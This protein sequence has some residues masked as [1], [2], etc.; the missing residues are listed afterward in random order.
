M[1]TDVEYTEQ[2]FGKKQTPRVGFQPT[3]PRLHDRCSTHWATEATTLRNITYLYIIINYCIVYKY[4]ISTIGKVSL[5]RNVWAKNPGTEMVCD[6]FTT[7]I[8]LYLNSFSFHQKS[9]CS[10]R[11]CCSRTFSSIIMEGK[12]E[13]F[14]IQRRR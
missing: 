1:K 4:C 11:C 2:M 3:T 12:V 7:S 14:E 13:S 5:T 10:W 9:F 6:F 8:I